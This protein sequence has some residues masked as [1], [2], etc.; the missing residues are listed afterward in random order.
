M[1]W[2]TLGLLWLG[3]LAAP[4]L[5]AKDTLQTTNNPLLWNIKGTKSWLF[6]TIHLPD[7]RLAK[8]PLAVEIAF[9]RSDAVYTEIPME[10][11]REI[12]AGIWLQRRDGKTLKQV[13]P[14]DVYAEL[15][16]YLQE[17]N[18]IFS[19]EAFNE[20]KTWVPYM[21]LTTQ[22]MKSTG[23]VLDKLL[24]KRAL[25]EGKEAGGLETIGEQVGYFDQFS[26][27]EM[28]TMIREGLKSYKKQPVNEILLKWYLEGN[29]STFKQVME[30]ISAPDADKALQDKFIDVL[31]TQRNKLMAERIVKKLKANPDQSY[32]F[33]VGAAHLADEKSV[34]YFL[35]EL[36][37][38]SMRVGV[39]F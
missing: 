36:G 27:E 39:G 21:L 34:Q 35:R 20:M 22:Q 4:P 9:R 14:A 1:K 10:F 38:E 6:G 33:A 37:Y 29:A 15:D 19:L 8:F 2:L 28:V 7:A 30:E 11:S 23:E 32:F 18:P 24:F 5:Y 12:S 31:L 3:L 25:Q 13:L 26:E 17:A 16:S